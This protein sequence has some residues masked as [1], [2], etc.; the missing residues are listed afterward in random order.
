MK[1]IPS[2]FL[3]TASLSLLIFFSLNA[4]YLVL[5]PLERDSLTLYNHLYEGRQRIVWKNAGM[6]VPLMNELRIPRLLVDHVVSRTKADNEYRLVIMGSSET[7]GYLLPAED[8]FPLV[9]DAMRLQTPDGQLI[10]SYNLAYVYSDIFKDLLITRSL[11]ENDDSPDVIIL[12]INP[13]SFDPL[14][15]VHWLVTGNHELAEDTVERYHLQNIDLGSVPD[16]AIWEDY[17]FLG[18]KLDLYNWLVNQLYGFRQSVDHP[19]PVELPHA[20]YQGGYLAWENKREGVLEAF[21]ELS[22]SQH[23]PL[24]L[25]ST[26]TNYYTPEYS[27][28][29]H[30]WSESHGIPLLD[31]SWLLPYT[32]FTDTALHMTPY[33]HEQLAAEVAAWLQDADDTTCENHVLKPD[34]YAYLDTHPAEQGVFQP[35]QAYELRTTLDPLWMADQLDDELAYFELRAIF[36]QASNEERSDLSQDQLDNIALWRQSKLPDYLR[37]AGFDK[38]L[39][40]KDW[41][42]WLTP[43]EQM[44]MSDENNYRPLKE[45]TFGEISYYLVELR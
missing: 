42:N 26:P 8:T 24:M 10:R 13:A 11:L 6:D 20:D 21:L 15:D 43:E 5:N 41:F 44:I 34:Y 32:E 22:E 12:A 39:V 3:K 28:W 14:E 9:L 37:E 16:Q 2:S 31:C 38:L 40:S 18:D 30:E 1:L 23:I 7:W 36:E 4:L 35:G 29:I 33:G 45:W 27:R 19:I 25:V 17:S